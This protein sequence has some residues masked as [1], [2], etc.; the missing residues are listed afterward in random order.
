MRNYRKILA[1]ILVLVL[2]SSMLTGCK[3][4]KS[5]FTSVME[6]AASFEKYTFQVAVDFDTDISNLVGYGMDITGTA[7]I[8]GAF[9][10]S[11]LSLGAKIDTDYVDFK[12]PELMVFKENAI[13]VNVGGIYGALGDFIHL[14]GE[15]DDM[16]DEVSWVELPV[17]K[18]VVD[19]S[20]MKKSQEL[21]VSIVSQMFDGF[22]FENDKNTHT[23]NIKKTSEFGKALK[24]GV[25]GIKKNEKN[26]KKLVTDRNLEDLIMD[27]VEIYMEAFI[28]AAKD[29]SSANGNFLSS[30]DINEMKEEIMD[31]LEDV[32][33]DMNL[34]DIDSVYD[35]L[36]DELDELEDMV[37]ELVE[38]MDDEEIKIKCS[39]S[40]S[41]AGKKGSREFTQNTSINLSNGSQEVTLKVKVTVTE[42]KDLEV[43][44][45][46]KCLELDGIMTKVFEYVGL[47]MAVPNNQ[48]EPIP[49]VNNSSSSNSDP[50]NPQPTTQPE[51]QPAPGG[52]RFSDGGQVFNI[53]ALNN[54]III[55]MEKYYPGYTRLDDSSGMIGNVKVV[56][57]ALPTEELLDALE[58]KLNVYGDNQEYAYDDEKVDAIILDGAYIRKFL[59]SDSTLTMEEIGFSDSKFYNQFPYTRDL[60]TVD[61]YQ[62]A[63]S[64]EVCAGGLIYRRDLAVQLFGTDDPGVVQTHLETWNDFL[65]VAEQLKNMNYYITATANDIFLP[66]MDNVASSFE[67]NL[68]NIDP[69]L[70]EYANTASF[71]V[72]NGYTTDE[73]QWGY[74]WSNGA[75]IDGNVFCYFGPDW[76]YKYSLYMYDPNSV[77]AAGGWGMCEG[78]E[79]FYWGGSWIAAAAGT[80]NISKVYDLIYYMTL[81]ED[82]L[83]SMTYNEGIVPNNTNVASYYEDNINLGSDIIG[84][85]NSMSVMISNAYEVS[86][87]YA[88]RYDD[89][90]FT[91]FKDIVRKEMLISGKSLDT[92]VRKFRNQAENIVFE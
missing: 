26:I 12:I 21:I 9:D 29:Y 43:K 14:Y 7:T 90:L 31:E 45:P 84:G 71:M 2:A 40:D 5:T 47:H 30:S 72:Q 42:D 70:M 11:A 15:L 67:G 59:E 60:V 41:I 80:D 46:K 83:S 63:S 18:K 28:D 32:I 64:Y 73:E 68:K 50:V 65:E 1:L 23:L 56:L 92:V 53:W 86:Q 13:Y 52:R 38:E 22:E 74:T 27:T 37:D 48:Q 6:D 44:V 85:Q 16:L 35:E 87:A 79:A 24:N 58:M 19:F 62:K 34:D 4:S 78:P 36:F 88:S 10:G 33:D 89:R 39:V 75:L 66:F 81:D 49:P 54:D 76:M 3:M 17:A 55:K 51:T 91:L 82:V 77:A 25:K 8:N 69:R 57:T 61:G 20:N